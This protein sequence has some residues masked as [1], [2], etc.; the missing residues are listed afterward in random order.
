ML[1]HICIAKN[2]EKKTREEIS[3]LQCFRH[4]GSLII[5]EKTGPEREEN[6]Q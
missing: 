4:D 1:C 6:T 5:A 2:A 3:I